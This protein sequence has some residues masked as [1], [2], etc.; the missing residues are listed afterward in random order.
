MVLILTVELCLADSDD[1][2]RHGEFSCLQEK[3]NHLK[4]TVLSKESRLKKKNKPLFKL[5]KSN[6]TL[7]A[8]RGLSQVDICI[9][10]HHRRLWRNQGNIGWAQ[11]N[12]ARQSLRVSLPLSY[13]VTRRG[14][15]CLGA[16]ERSAWNAWFSSGAPEVITGRDRAT[17]VNVLHFDT[18]MR[19]GWRMGG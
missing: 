4:R 10:S 7:S 18:V 19:K 8:G 6:Q 15:S 3:S 17:D 14:W 11:T 12:I 16:T 9:L 2:D 13:S 5:P 1:D